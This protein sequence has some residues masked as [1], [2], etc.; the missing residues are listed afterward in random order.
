VKSA[1]IHMRGP[2]YR[3][4]TATCRYERIQPSTG[5]WISYAFTLSIVSLVFL[6]ALLLV[7]DY[8]NDTPTELALRKENAALEK[9]QVIFSKQLEEVDSK[10]NWL[11]KKDNE[12]H[13]KLF[14]SASLPVPIKSVELQQRKIL[15]ADA[16]TFSDFVTNFKDASATLIK[17]SLKANSDHAN[18]AELKSGDLNT[19]A[20]IPFHQ[21]IKNLEPE[22][23]LSGFGIRINPFH[24]GLC[25]H[26][27]IDISV[28][29]GTEV[30]ATAPGQVITARKSG[31]LAGYGNFIEV[32]HRNGFTT[33]YAHLEELNVK[34]GQKIERGS[35]IATTGNSGGSVAP[36]LHY[37][38]IRNGKQ[39]DPVKYMI[40]GI[41]SAQ[42]DQIISI[43]QRENQS[44]D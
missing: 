1:K 44:L 36:H 28:P 42:H 23:I 7:H 37:E 29:R 10:L 27:G 25:D 35:V 34:V 20:S 17:N 33:R 5:T 24:K 4:N 15:F 41:G 12:L 21:P 13:G 40:S 38:I 3:Y 18:H 31:L 30:L 2:T 32:D 6:I 9:Y 19:V 22:K 39:V 16:R 11:N 43:S 14:S 8:L 26:P